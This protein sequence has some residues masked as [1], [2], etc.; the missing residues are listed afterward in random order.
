MS[1]NTRAS[2]LPEDRFV[3]TASEVLLQNGR[4]IRGDELTIGTLGRGASIV[5]PP[6]DPAALGALNRALAARGV[7]W[8]YGELAPGAGVIDSGGV[9]GR[10]LL[11]K[12][13][14]IVSTGRGTRTAYRDRT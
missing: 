6:G 11:H 13:Y 14:A 12:R 2:W 8:R 7:P 10:H 1:G 9:L 4:L 3:A 5:Q